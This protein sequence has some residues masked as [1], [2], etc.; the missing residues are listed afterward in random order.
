MDT[1]MEMDKWAF[2]HLQYGSLS[3]VMGQLGMIRIIILYPKKSYTC[4][5]KILLETLFHHK[6]KFLPFDR[7]P[8]TSP[9]GKPSE[10]ETNCATMDK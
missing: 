9:T 2:W 8:T 6:S 5:N 3:W 1:G 4:N 7:N 10:S